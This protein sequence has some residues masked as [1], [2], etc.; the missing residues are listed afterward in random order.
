[1]PLKHVTPN[2]RA[3]MTESWVADMKKWRSPMRAVLF[4]VAGCACATVPQVRAGA[5]SCGSWTEGAP[6][7]DPRWFAEAGQ[8]SGTGPSAVGNARR[9]ALAALSERVSVTIKA[10]LSSRESQGESGGKSFTSSQEVQAIEVST[11]RSFDDVETVA[12]C[13]QR[14]TTF[15]LAGVRRSKYGEQ[16]QRRLD[17]LSGEMAIIEKSLDQGLPLQRLLSRRRRLL[18]GD[19][20][21]AEAAVFRAVVG[22]EPTGAVA[23]HERL[24]REF[25]EVTAAT[26]VAVEAPAGD[27]EMASAIGAA[28]SA[29]GVHPG[30]PGRERPIVAARV[31]TSPATHVTDGLYLVR[32]QLVVTLD[33]RGGSVIA[34]AE[35][36]HWYFINPRYVYNGHRLTLV[37]GI[38]RKPRDYKASN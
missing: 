11:A 38:T 31:S 16:A 32:A 37:H 1:M 15:V 2:G 10:S 4:L 23:S 12:T 34:S 9:K 28:L 22:E 21:H 6:F 3:S 26:P 14:G 17:A 35:Q 13:V 20:W 18:L 27:P 29:Q 33:G 25:D 24:Q 36:V 19:R 5:E 8:S 30:P 7:R